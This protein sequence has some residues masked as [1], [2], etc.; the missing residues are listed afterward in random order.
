MLP[1]WLLT[2]IAILSR[3][4]NAALVQKIEA[5][6]FN[7]AND[8]A[9]KIGACILASLAGATPTTHQEASVLAEAQEFAASV[10]A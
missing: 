4:Q 7:P 5:C 3:L 10:N 1:G 8:S 9:Q 6:M 2:L